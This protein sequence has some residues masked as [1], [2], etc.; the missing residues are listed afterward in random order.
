MSFL[1]LFLFFFGS[2]ILFSKNNDDP[3]LEKG[4]I[5]QKFLFVGR[6]RLANLSS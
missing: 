4:H 3:R 2:T 1:F 5:F 6:A